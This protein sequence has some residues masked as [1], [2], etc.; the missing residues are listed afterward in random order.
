MLI[1]SYQIEMPRGS[2]LFSLQGHE[3]PHIQCAIL[4]HFFTL[5]IYRCA[6]KPLNH[7][8]MLEIQPCGQLADMS[9]SNALADLSLSPGL[10]SCCCHFKQQQKCPKDNF[11]RLCFIASSLLAVWLSYLKHIILQHTPDSTDQHIS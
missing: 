6:S 5:S 1:N 2:R 3:I 9:C 8:F 7:I 10:R 11:K 4:H